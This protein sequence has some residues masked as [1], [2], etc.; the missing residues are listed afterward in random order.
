MSLNSCG[1]VPEAVLSPSKEGGQGDNSFRACPGTMGTSRGQVGTSHKPCLIELSP[2][3]GI[4]EE[5][6]GE[7]QSQK[8]K[9]CPHGPGTS[10]NGQENPSQTSA[11]RPSASLTQIESWLIEKRP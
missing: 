10:L 8:K 3:F 5:K 1:P 11:R 2:C 6:K 9:T 7:F 4:G